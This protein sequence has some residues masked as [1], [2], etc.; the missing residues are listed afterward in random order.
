MR[1]ANVNAVLT[2]RAD[3]ELEL[4][5][6]G[7]R[8]PLRFFRRSA[9]VLFFASSRSVEVSDQYADVAHVTQGPGHSQCCIRRPGRL[10]LASFP[11]RGNPA[12]I[13][14]TLAGR[15]SC[16]RSHSLARARL[17][18]RPGPRSRTIPAPMMPP[19]PAR[20]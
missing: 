3:D 11:W 13:P 18:P 17:S 6:N 16:L 19:S 14:Q 4:Y 7:C 5:V 15:L 20:P 8:M 10:P 9:H 2:E 12:K 1:D